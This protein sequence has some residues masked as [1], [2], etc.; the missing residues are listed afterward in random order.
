MTDKQVTRRRFLQFSAVI[1]AGGVLAACAPTPAPT[2]APKATQPP[3]ATAAPK[4][5]QPPA[6]ATAVPKPTGYTEAP[7][8][9]EQVKT[10]KL[11]PVNER[12]PLN[13]KVWDD[14]DAVVFET[15]KGEYGGTLR[16]GHIHD[17]QATATIGMG[18]IAADRSTFYTDVAEKWE[19]SPD[20][21]Q[22]TVY[23]R[24]GHRWSDGTP[25]TSDHFVFWYNEVVQSKY[26]TN[27]MGVMGMDSKRDKIVK[28][29]DYT[30]RWEFFKPNP[31]YLLRARGFGDGETGNSFRL[32]M[33]YVKKLHPDYSPDSQF[34]DA[35]EQ[36]Q[37]KIQDQIGWYRCME[38]TTR[39]VLWPW[40]PMEY[41]EGQLARLERNPYYHI[42]DRWGRQLP[43]ID[44]M[45]DFLLADT[46]T[47]VILAKLLAG[48]THWERRRTSVRVV[49]MLREAE[50]TGVVEIVFTTKPEGSPQGILFNPSHADPNWAALIGNADFRRALSVAIDRE[51]INQTAFYGMGKPG[52]GFSDSG[53]YDPN[54]DGKWAQ[55]DPALANKM[56][57]ALGLTKRDAEGFR[58][59]ADGSKLT[60]TLMFQPGWQV[61]ADE[62]AELS[63]DGWNKVGVRSVTKAT[64]GAQRT[65]AFNTR[66]Y[67]A[68]VNPWVGGVWDQN[69]Q[70]GE[71]MSRLAPNEYKWWLATD[72]PEAQR[73]GVKP[74]GSILEFLKMEDIIMNTTDPKEREATI[75]KRRE[76]H[77]DQMWCLGMVTNLPHVIG[78][79]KKLRGV[80]GRTDVLKYYM[81][82]G[83]EDFWPQ[84]WFFAK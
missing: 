3:A 22:F 26:L 43:Y 29:D 52:H 45:E 17:I 25:L 47:E 14:P 34:K 42:V 1:T 66:Q 65:E 56:L 31:I 7:M 13:P 64:T 28:I 54:V 76:L 84:S 21:K 81:G 77:A 58:T 11:P 10:G 82:G 46:D 19:M 39:P 16:Y 32:A 67:E 79:N 35:K 70:Y 53:V 5:T 72:L 55:Y 2:V 44:Y 69:L 40:R 12:L 48:E 6:A 23:L 62:V 57:D 20:F 78:V 63:V 41:K 73:P 9:A 15:E 18:R 24:K 80:W 59:F 4:A 51:A 30:F 75:Q 68:W 37:K 60:F 38:D 83:D 61:G 36:W 71:G 74:E 27:P 33:H 8:L 50:K 49:P